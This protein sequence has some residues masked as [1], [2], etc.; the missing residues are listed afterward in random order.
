M[1]VKELRKA[2]RGAP[3][4]LPVV[5]H[6]QTEDGATYAGSP[7]HAKHMVYLG[8]RALFIFCD[9]EGSLKADNE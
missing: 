9:P 8:D 4:N 2:L 7:W 3:G 5:V 6:V 1:T